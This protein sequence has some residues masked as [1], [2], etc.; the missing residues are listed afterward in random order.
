MTYK[1]V[2][3]YCDIHIPKDYHNW[4][5]AYGEH[6]RTDVVEWIHETMVDPELIIERDFKT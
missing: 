5:I 3:E 1:T 4:F 2:Q 6:D